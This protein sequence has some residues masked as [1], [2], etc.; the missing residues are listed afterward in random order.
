MS[1]S[2]TLLNHHRL[3]TIQSIIS[4][5]ADRA[6]PRATLVP[7]L[8]C[9]LFLSGTSP[10]LKPSWGLSGSAAQMKLSYPCTR[11]PAGPWEQ[12]CSLQIQQGLLRSVASQQHFSRILILYPANL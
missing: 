10:C 4:V 3:H 2:L 9:S 8:Q 7:R 1:S 6:G 11:T 12:P 5:Y